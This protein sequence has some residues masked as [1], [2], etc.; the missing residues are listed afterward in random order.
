[1][2]AVACPAY[3]VTAVQVTRAEAK[4]ITFDNDSRRRMQDGINKLAAAVG[5]TLGPRGKLA[6]M[7]QDQTWAAGCAAWFSPDGTEH[8]G[9]ALQ[10]SLLTEGALTA[11][12]S[13]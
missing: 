1:M 8:L 3:K 10:I 7:L 2:K 12:V 11:R 5:S 13:L 9:S 6:Y 4:E